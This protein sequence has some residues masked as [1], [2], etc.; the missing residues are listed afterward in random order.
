MYRCISMY[1]CV[2]PYI[3]I[4][5]YLCLTNSIYLP[6]MEVGSNVQ[7]DPVDLRNGAMRGRSGGLVAWVFG[8]ALSI[9]NS[10]G[11]FLLSNPIFYIIYIHVYLHIYIYTYIHIYIFT[12]IHLHIY[13]SIHTYFHLCIYT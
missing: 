4:I 13:T 9:A 3:H 11:G 2:Y 7:F 5:S 10:H 1:I 8:Q 12:Y 6:A